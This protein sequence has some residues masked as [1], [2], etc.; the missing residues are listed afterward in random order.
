MPIV[1]TDDM[2]A[3]DLKQ[4]IAENPNLDLDDLRGLAQRA[5][6][7]E[8]VGTDKIT[9]LYSGRVG[10]DDHSE[11]IAKGLF[12]NDSAKVGIINETEAAKLLTSGEFSGAIDA[13]IKRLNPNIDFTTP[14][15][16]EELEN[17]RNA[18]LFATNGGMWSISSSKLASQASGDVVV[19][20]SPD[21]E[22]T[23]VFAQDELPKLLVNDDVTSINGISK[24]DLA[25]LN[26]LDEAFA[27]VQITGGVMLQKLERG[28][29]TGG[30][31]THKT[32][33]FFKGINGVNGDDFPSGAT[34]T[35]IYAEDFKD[36]SPYSSWMGEMVDKFNSPM[37]QNALD[38]LGSL[39]AVGFIVLAATT[40]RIMFDAGEAY[41]SGNETLGDSL[42][43]TAFDNIGSWIAENT[44][45]LLGEVAA[46]AAVAATAIILGGSIAAL[47]ILGGAITLAAAV[48]GGAYAED[49]IGIRSI[50]ES[51]GLVESSDKPVTVTIDGVEQTITVNDVYVDQ[52][53][54]YGN[55]GFLGEL[56]DNTPDYH[57]STQENATIVGH[58]ADD[59]VQG[60]D[61]DDYLDGV[62]GDDTII[63]EGGND[64]LA[65]GID[66][67]I[68]DGGAGIDTA[69]YSG[70][71]FGSRDLSINLNLGTAG[72]GGIFS[73]NAD[74]LEDTLYNIENAIGSKGDDTITGN[75]EANV[76]D[77]YYGDDQLTGGSGTDT[78]HLNDAFGHDYIVDDGGVLLIAGKVPVISADGSRAQVTDDEGNLRE[79]VIGRQA[80]VTK[81][82]G[83]AI[84]EDDL[85]LTEVLSTGALS[86]YNSIIIEDYYPNKANWNF[87]L[88]I[89]A[90]VSLIGGSSNG[91]AL[92]DPTDSGP[93]ADNIHVLGTVGFAEIINNQDNFDLNG[94]DSSFYVHGGGGADAI[95]FQG[96]NGNHTI[97]GG[98]QADIL[99]AGDGIDTFRY[100]SHLDSFG[101]SGR[102]SILHFTQGQD[103]IDVTGLGFTGIAAHN[104]G[105]VNDLEYELAYAGTSTIPYT[106][107]S[108]DN[109]GF[110]IAFSSGHINFVA[111]D[112]LGLASGA[113][114]TDG[115]HND[116]ALTGGD[117]AD[118]IQG[119]GG[120][121]I[122]ELRG[123]NDV[124]DGGAGTDTIVYQASSANYTINDL[125]SQTITVTDNVGSDGVDSLT[126][127]EIL[128][129]SDQ[130]LYWDG[131][132][133]GATIPDA[134][135][136]AL[137]ETVSTNYENAVTIDVLFNDS[138]AEDDILDNS[139]LSINTNPS[140][141]SVN[142]NN[143]GTI[144]YTPNTGFSGSDSFVY[145]LTD[146][147]GGTDTAT[148][149]IT[150][151]AAPAN[152]A[153][154]AVNDTVTVAYETAT[155]LSVLANDTDDET[156]DG[157]NITIDADPASGVVVVNTDGT[158]TYTPNA[159][160]DGVDSFDYTITDAAGNVD[161]ATVS[162]TVNPE[163]SNYAPTADAD[164]AT[165]LMGDTVDID[166]L[167]NDTDVEDTSFA[168][169]NLSIDT[170][171]EHGSV[172]IQSNGVITF[173]P[174]QSYV[175]ADSF[176][177]TLTD[178]GGESSTAIVN[179]SVL[180]DID[181]N[182][183]ATH[184]GD[185]NDNY[186]KSASANDTLLGLDGND[187]LY[188]VAG[189]D[190]LVGGLGD[191]T[192]WGYSGNDTYIWASGDGNDLVQESNVSGS[193]TDIL[194]F[195]GGIVLSDLEIYGYTSHD[196]KIKYTPTGEILTLQNQL[197]SDT[198]YSVETLTFDDGS[199]YNLIQG[200]KVQG[201]ASNEALYGT[202][203]DDTM[204]G[205]QGDDIID[206]ET[207]NDTL[208]G[209]IGNDTLYGG[210]GDDSYVWRVGDGDDLLIENNSGGTDTLLLTGGITLNDVKVY[211]YTSHD[212][213]V[214]YIPTGETLTL[215]NLHYSDADYRIESITFDDGT[216]YNLDQAAL[217]LGGVGSQNLQGSV[218]NDTMRGGKDNDTV[219]GGAGDDTLY[220][221][222][223]DDV[224][225][226][227]AGD[228][229]Y[230]WEAG[231]GN[232]ILVESNSGGTDTL[233]LKG[234]ITFSDLHIYG[235]TS[236]DLRIEYIPTGETLTL[237]NLHY[238]DTD[239]HIET[240]RFD[241]GATYD[242][243]TGVQWL[244]GVGNQ[245]LQGSIYD[246]LMN[247]GKD[248]DTL[249]G[250][251][252]DDTLSG[253]LGD[254]YL[255]GSSGND[256]YLWKAGDGNDIFTEASNS[257]STNDVVFLTGGITLADLDMYGTTSHDV[258]IVHTPT[259]ETI[260][261]QN[262]LY[263]DVD[264]HFEFIRFQDGTTYNLEQGYEIRGDTGNDN[265]DGG[266]YDDTMLGNTGNDTLEGLAGN[267]VF[268]GG[269]GIDR[270]YGGIGDD[271]Y[272][273][274]SGDG[275]DW[276][277][278]QNYTGSGSD[279]L[280]LTGGIVAADVTF[281]QT[282]NDL[283]VN[284]TP[285]G[286]SIRIDNQYLSDPDYK[287]ETLLFDNGTTMDLLG[288]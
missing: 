28:V 144:T 135:P 129:F 92:I 29:N 119:N 208:Y 68:L 75:G 244:G 38:K 171:P 183:T 193:G 158:I 55:K 139:N 109:T 81:P 114:T 22:V 34:L 282:G 45:G 229:T 73:G 36:G 128:Q 65:G 173:T 137:G 163:P 246:D 228:D 1:L 278:E 223:G 263:S 156:L 23:R 49:L 47:G 266:A 225:Y 83:S 91:F 95:I 63:G 238:S 215:Q 273:W 222:L 53:H 226:G 66:T 115:D 149:N 284:Y 242:L 160:Y 235:Y 46:V 287:V 96:T 232:D 40:I 50:A 56:I 26:D 161:T 230:I 285:T 178:S 251:A 62:K 140:N 133:W 52:L 236:H 85:L 4:Y 179:V 221:D 87:N 190:Q 25:A 143:S 210:V 12:N 58:D 197:Y 9:V 175:G 162:I 27:R 203:Y 200:M 39:K 48:L 218:Y 17:L 248:D 126:N 165:V 31:E 276:I 108:N 147:A 64:T 131:T 123:G 170:A 164:T 243:Q 261:L 67:N 254:D 195:T 255:K 102:D 185:A 132:S 176:T 198:D 213:R 80:G 234:G 76:L 57:K 201:S 169:S 18:E 274:A 199:S 258:K 121:D 155:I 78:Y 70:T 270:L 237:Q 124:A 247:G 212:M 262:H 99:S 13:E 207:G 184:T 279:T 103:K 269:V 2:T 74:N 241:D 118:T 257:G 271:T 141:G 11:N 32:D 168:G 117:F 188:G 107:L 204:R 120:D 245:H 211:G 101:T 21:A 187:T 150:V 84:T 61:G 153:P 86:P 30:F 253:D 77:G 42:M 15:G 148:V 97:V 33:D 89:G 43:Q 69:D 10:A 256:T 14:E 233:Y 106:I 202:V 239:Y 7:S 152:D 138:D 122:L 145:T 240:L 166:V 272:L 206:G 217:W 220:G 113:I 159:T 259:G 19:I 214:E 44:E 189:D 111:S 60:G 116:N 283:L 94:R 172:S 267:D 3:D 151:G 71:P 5:D 252:G 167:A 51:L 59:V 209:D 93:L 112:F 286:E 130:T 37:I 281:T 250:D 35:K 181:P 205:G 134:A 6:I 100:E 125:N 177:Y 90:D 277:Y 88:G 260:T 249:S 219:N 110:E 180:A 41:A 265:L 79:F 157:G 105:G 288:V 142:I 264:Y 182:A 82:D 216:S 275:N 20:L 24:N 54:T 280:H 136:N 146:S 186:I 154:D 72:N 224:V 174:N 192:L 231:R 98:L 16:L 8:A 127:V 194:H 104:T 196:L 268:D 191:D 227:G